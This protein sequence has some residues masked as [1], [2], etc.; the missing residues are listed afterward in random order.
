MYLNSLIKKLCL[1][2]SARAERIL[3]KHNS[4]FYRGILGICQHILSMLSGVDPAKYDQHDIVRWFV[5]ARTDGWKCISCEQDGNIWLR[6]ILHRK[7]HVAVC[8][9]QNLNLTIQRSDGTIV[10]N[11]FP[12]NPKDFKK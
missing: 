6:A 7:G 3:A 11:K 2:E 1:A 10:Y 8:D 12:Y 4:D 9:L 5:A